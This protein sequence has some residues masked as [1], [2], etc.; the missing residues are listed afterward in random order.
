MKRCR[1]TGFQH[2]LPAT[3][4]TC[5]YMESLLKGVSTAQPAGEG[6]LCGKIFMTWMVH[7]T[8]RIRQIL[9]LNTYIIH[10]EMLENTVLGYLGPVSR[11]P[12]KVFAPRKR[13]QNLKPYD[14]RAV[15]FTYT[16]NANMAD[17]SVVARD[18][19]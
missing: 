1:K 5:Y 16:P 3:Q 17:H 19:S 10:A 7:V 6:V 2:K 18:E 12:R 11:R 13:E 4:A 15:L 14:Y 8:G 9:V